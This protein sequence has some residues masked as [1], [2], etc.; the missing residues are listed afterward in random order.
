MK[1][2]ACKYTLKVKNERTNVCGLGTNKNYPKTKCTVEESGY[3]VCSI[4]CVCVC[5]RACMRA[6][7]C[8][9]VCVCMSACMRVCVG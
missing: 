8:L 3:L 2:T 6:C 4:M 7:V 5:V 9:Y 1:H